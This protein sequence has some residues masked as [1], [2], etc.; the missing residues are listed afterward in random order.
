MYGE[1]SFSSIRPTFAVSFFCCSS[2]LSPCS[3]T[4]ASWLATCEKSSDILSNCS[5]CDDMA[6]TTC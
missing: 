6:S 5:F 2:G 1:F 3:F 4:C